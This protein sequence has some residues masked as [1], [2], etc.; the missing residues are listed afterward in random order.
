MEG[1]FKVTLEDEFKKNPELKAED[2]EEIQTWI[3]TQPH[4][5]TVPDLM[6][7]LFLHACQWN[8]EDTKK[9]IDIYYTLKTEITEF[10][11]DRDPTS[12]EIKD[13]AKVNPIVMLPQSD[14]QGN[15]ILW[16]RL[17]ECDPKQYDFAA[18]VK[19]N[20]MTT[21]VFQL[22]NGTV[23]GLV[24]VNDC[25]HFNASVFW[26]TPMKLGSS[27][28]RFTQEAASYPVKACH[29]INAHSFLEK[30]FSIIKPL[31]RSKVYEMFHMH[32]NMESLFKVIPREIVPKDYGGE[33]LTLEELN[34]LN[35]QKLE[36]Y[37]QYFQD[38]RTMRVDE[39]KR[40]GKA[41]KSEFMDWTKGWWLS[42]M[43]KLSF[44]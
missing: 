2:I 22:E 28:T 25:K 31:F 43:R 35:L 30:C 27:Y 42:A 12:Q 17:N 21:E 7:V 44:K 20:T 40:V 5:P 3:K 24:I 4:L 23:P 29:Y 11:A 14:P 13:I 1:M 38:E 39:S 26:S 37:R 41:P 16:I 34:E 6:I 36:S 32:S 33:G 9:T 10:F 18:S 8:L 15:R 19:Y